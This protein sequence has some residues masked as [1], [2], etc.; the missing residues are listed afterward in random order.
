MGAEAAAGSAPARGQALMPSRG[1]AFGIGA[2]LNG[3][4]TTPLPHARVDRNH[5]RWAQGTSQ[6]VKAGRAQDFQFRAR[7]RRRA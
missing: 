2:A 3:A 4:A 6:S 5:N 1:P 7:F